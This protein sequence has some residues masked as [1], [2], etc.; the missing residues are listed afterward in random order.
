MG[1]GGG[2]APSEEALDAQHQ[3]FELGAGGAL[4][5]VSGSEAAHEAIDA[6]AAMT[7]SQM[8]TQV[9]GS[10]PMTRRQS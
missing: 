2:G 10:Q 4:S 8:P 9:V 5:E 7:L 3:D 1:G 6:E